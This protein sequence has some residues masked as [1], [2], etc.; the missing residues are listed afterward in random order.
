MK[1]SNMNRDEGS[2][3]LN[4]LRDKLRKLDWSQQSKDSPY[5]SLRFDAKSP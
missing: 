4:Y 2:Y 1:K 3:Q 5:E